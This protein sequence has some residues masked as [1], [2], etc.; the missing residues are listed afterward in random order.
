MWSGQ[1]GLGMLD[2]R[3]VF[4]FFFL[5][6]YALGSCCICSQLP[7]PDHLGV[8]CFKSVLLF[9]FEFCLCVNYLSLLNFINLSFSLLLQLF[10]YFWS[11]ILSQCVSYSFCKTDLECIQKWKEYGGKYSREINKKHM[12]WCQCEYFNNDCWYLY[13]TFHFH[14]DK[15][16]HLYLHML[17]EVIIYN[18]AS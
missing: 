18:N 8:N 9:V 1:G 11:L 10:K 13:S 16:L 2:A 12:I 5:K 3:S 14:C 4:F 17:S 7:G 15:N 6:H